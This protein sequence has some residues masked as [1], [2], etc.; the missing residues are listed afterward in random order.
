MREEYEAF[1]NAKDDDSNEAVGKEEALERDR[2]MI[3][4][5]DD[6]DSGITNESTENVNNSAGNVTTMFQK[7]ML[8]G[9][10]AGQVVVNVGGDGGIGQTTE[11]AISVPNARKPTVHH[12]G[13]MVRTN[14]RLCRG[15]SCRMFVE[16]S[17]V[18]LFSLLFHF[19]F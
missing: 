11:N 12:Q 3:D 2:D 4:N 15:I 9:G 7:L 1:D 8:L 10:G 14:V 18:A 6:E 16:I 13:R 19:I 17:D 5:D